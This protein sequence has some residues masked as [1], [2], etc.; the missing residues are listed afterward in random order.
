MSAAP[1]QEVLDREAVSQ[2]RRRIGWLVEA[3]AA[4]G[5]PARLDSLAREKSRIE[6]ELREARGMG[7]R[8][9]A[10]G[11]TPE[12]KARQRVR[13][14]VTYAGEKLSPAA[15]ALARHFRSSVRA[16]AYA[17]ACLP[18]GDPPDWAL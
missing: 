3:L 14:A 13:Q 6:R 8:M 10:L 5:D 9:R 1:T 15:P 2:Y 11:S 7:G 16:D 12:E 18:A 4:T 17:Y